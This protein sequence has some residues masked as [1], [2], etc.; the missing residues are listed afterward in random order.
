MDSIGLTVNDN[1]VVMVLLRKGLKGDPFLENYRLV[2]LEEVSPE[3]REG[4]LLSNIEGFIDQNKGDR[5]NLFLGIPG[6]KVI[7]KRLSLPSP[8]EENL[9][10]VLGFEMDRYTPFTL[11]DVYFDF[12]V[13]KRDEEKKLIHVL[14]MVVKKEVVDYY[15]KL[16]QRI[17]IKVRGIEVTSTALYNAIVKKGQVGK[18]GLDK[19]WIV[20]GSKWLRARSWGKKLVAPWE[21]FLG[22]GGREETFAEGSTR[23]LVNIDD[24][25]CELGV[26]RDNALIYSRC[27]NLSRRSGE[28]DADEAVEGQVEGILSEIETT[29]LSLGDGSSGISQLIVSGNGVDQNLIDRLKEKEDIDA[30]LI[31]SLNININDVREEVPCLS[32][33]IGLALKGLKGVALDVNFIPRELRPKRKKN[34]SLICGVTVMVLFLMGIS[35]FTISFFVKERIYLAELSERVDAL[36]GRVREIERMQE[37][38]TDIEGKMGSVEKI[39]VEDVSKLNILKELTLIIPEEMWLTRFSYNE[40]KGKRS[41]DLSGYAEAASEIITILEESELFEDVKFKSSIV[42][43]RKKDKEKFNVTATVSSD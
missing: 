29:R 8:T 39:K 35:S 43:D 18:N 22:K 37:E 38:I 5:D 19:E 11:D 4:I 31:D 24:D 10:E 12:K 7:F 3:D 16:L 32:A 25:C 15:L 27:F 1:R 20:K 23:F 17:N 42:K 41:V 13:V 40:K 14:L 34:W 6:N 36:K 9:K 30:R 28:T 33:A 2:S 21:R 26:V